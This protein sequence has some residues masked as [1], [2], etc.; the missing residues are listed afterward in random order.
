MGSNCSDISARRLQRLSLAAHD[1][2][3]A[4]HGAGSDGARAGFSGQLAAWRDV[5]SRRSQSGEAAAFFDWA[6]RV[7]GLPENQFV[8]AVE[9]LEKERSALA[10]RALSA[11]GTPRL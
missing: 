3:A 7:S 2:L 5:A 6:S 9:V 4:M 1:C 11:G 8:A 10:D